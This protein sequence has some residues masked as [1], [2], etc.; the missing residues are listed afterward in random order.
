MPGGFDD[1]YMPTPQPE[2]VSP[3]P[4]RYRNPHSSR[5][6]EME[7]I[8]LPLLHSHRIMHEVPENMQ[9]NIEHLELAANVPHDR[10]RQQP[11][12]SWDSQG[13]SQTEPQGPNNHAA[14]N[15]RQSQ[16]YEG[17]ASSLQE[18]PN[19]SP[20][21]RLTNPPPNVPPTYD[22]KEAILEQARLPVLNSNDPEMQLAWAQDAL[23]Y[24]QIILQDEERIAELDKRPQRPGT[25]AIEHQLKVDA[26]NIVDFLAQQHHPKAEFMKGMWL[27]F[28]N[29]GVR[30]DKREAFRCY[31]RAAEKGY[32]RAEY[33]MG[34][35]FEQN[36]DPAKA[37][38][39]YRRGAD[40]G[41][42]ASNYVGRE[43]TKR[44]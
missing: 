32:T 21:P 37:L 44:K 25:P 12:Q 40:A 7:I 24:V 10:Q 30:Q 41:D 2:L 6:P 17:F 13:Y 23:A 8:G 31:A 16:Y 19:F 11:S 29:F 27:E 20:F 22:E 14:P 33:R 35:Q 18:L 43:D 26:M 9:D 34:M 5:A 38:H 4:Q 15:H 3:S 39:H 1:Y 36:N 42:A 28:G